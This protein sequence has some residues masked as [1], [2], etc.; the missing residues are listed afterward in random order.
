M[1]RGKRGTRGG[2]V[3]VDERAQVGTINGAAVTLGAD[4]LFRATREDCILATCD[5][6]KTLEA[7]VKKL[8]REVTRD[9]FQGAL[10]VVYTDGDPSYGSGNYDAARVF[11]PVPLVGLSQGNRPTLRVG[12][13]RVSPKGDLHLFRGEDAI[14]A[15]LL[16][17]L[18]RVRLASRKYDEAEKDLHALCEREGESFRE[19][20]L[21][22]ASRATVIAEIREAI[23]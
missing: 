11:G 20:R 4:G 23:A 13:K 7:E 21:R 15:E 16:A 3:A 18:E 2:S 8:D 14:A 1:T 12:G 10:V 19:Y 17:A 6:F 9:E 5:T 22:T